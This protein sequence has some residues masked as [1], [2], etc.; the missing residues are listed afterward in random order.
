MLRRPRAHDEDLLQFACDEAGFVAKCFFGLSKRN[1]LKH[2]AREVG[3]TL[4]IVPGIQVER[5]ETDVYE[6][7]SSRVTSRGASTCSSVGK[8]ENEAIHQTAE[9]IRQSLRN[10]HCCNVLVLKADG[11]VDVSSTTSWKSAARK[12]NET[13]LIADQC[14]SDCQASENC[15]FRST[16]DSSSCTNG[17]KDG[18][19]VCT[20]VEEYKDS[21]EQR[22]Y[23]IEEFNARCSPCAPA[24]ECAIGFARDSGGS[25]GKCKRMSSTMKMGGQTPTCDGICVAVKRTSSTATLDEKDDNSLVQLNF[26][27]PR[28]SSPSSAVS[29]KPTVHSVGGYA[30]C[31][32]TGKELKEY[33]LEE[34]LIH[35]GDTPTL[36]TGQTFLMG[37]LETPFA[38]TTTV[39]TCDSC[40]SPV[41]LTLD[42]NLVSPRCGARFHASNSMKPNRKGLTYYNNTEKCYRSAPN[43]RTGISGPFGV[44]PSCV[45]LGKNSVQAHRYINTVGGSSSFDVFFDTT[46][47]QAASRESQQTL[48]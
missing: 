31:F 36:S 45:E 15:S 7:A 30:Q 44:D 12:A 18:S 41:A 9:P 35:P 10:N 13:S 14:K 27:A 21:C 6:G 5:G 24:D 34:N 8:E 40:V 19:D 47:A 17:P 38:E 37:I 16:I 48:R 46:L 23:R 11:A 22:A 43:A 33:L 26:P 32:A 4:E 2:Y 39:V 20:S 29:D 25:A 42:P 3:S 1:H 28:E